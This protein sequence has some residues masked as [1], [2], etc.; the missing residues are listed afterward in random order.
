MLSNSSN[1][2]IPSSGGRH[3]M[4]FANVDGLSGM[5]LVAES[6][7]KTIS[8]HLWNSCAELRQTKMHFFLKSY[9]LGEKL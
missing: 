6:R 5:A 1:K 8:S 2:V 7:E 3:G 4:E 9:M